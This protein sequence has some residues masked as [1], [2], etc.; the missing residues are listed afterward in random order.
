[1]FVVPQSCASFIGNPSCQSC[2]RSRLYS[3]Q[4]FQI[5]Y[6]FFPGS[7]AEDRKIG[8]V[9]SGARTLGV[10][11]EESCWVPP[12]SALLPEEAEKILLLE[13]STLQQVSNTSF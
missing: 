10:L 8:K 9:A 2:I 13:E 6:P 4:I 7:K 12:S 5:R 1:M 11:L 3:E